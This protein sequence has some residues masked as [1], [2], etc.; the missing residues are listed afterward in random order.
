LVFAT[1][2]RS[3]EVERRRLG[4]LRARA[5]RGRALLELALRSTLRLEV[6]P[7]HMSC[8]RHTKNHPNITLINNSSSK[9]PFENR[10]L[11]IPFS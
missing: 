11:F 6:G 2:I 8:S 1:P 3:A 9:T 4:T 5:L 7:L 10:Q